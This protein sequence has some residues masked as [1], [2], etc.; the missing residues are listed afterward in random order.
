ML[1]DGVSWRDIAVPIEE[2]VWPSG[3]GAI[4]GFWNQYEVMAQSQNLMDGLYALRIGTENF[5]TLSFYPDDILSFEIV[6]T[7]WFFSKHYPL[8]E[9]LGGLAT[10]GTKLKIHSCADCL[11]RFDDGQDAS[12]GN[13][14]LPLFERIIHFPDITDIELIY[15]PDYWAK[16]SVKEPYSPVRPNKFIRLYPP[17]DDEGS[18]PDNAL[19]KGWLDNDGNLNIEWLA[20]PCFCADDNF[21]D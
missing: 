19:Q 10:C 20:E 9:S 11:D 8:R 4:N 13:R 16:R 15:D 18:D 2:L 6:N 1:D 3:R 5:S 17:Y 7:T 14:I 12:V 21:E